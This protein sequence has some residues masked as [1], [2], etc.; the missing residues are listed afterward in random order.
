MRRFIFWL[1]VVVIA[2]IGVIQLVPYGR[3]HTNP[4]VTQ[5][6]AWDRPETRMLAVRAC[7]DCHS[8]ETV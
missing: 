6:P 1:A 4:P 7:F 5:E 8:N 2:A 3:D